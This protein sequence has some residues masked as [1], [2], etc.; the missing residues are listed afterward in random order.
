MTDPAV[1]YLPNSGYGPFDHGEAS[2][3][4]LKA[5]DGS[6]FLGVVWPGKCPKVVFCRPHLIFRLRCDRFSR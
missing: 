6:D 4:W 3:V 1:A 2:G 5:A